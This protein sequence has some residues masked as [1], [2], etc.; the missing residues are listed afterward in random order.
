MDIGTENIDGAPAHIKGRVRYHYAT[1]ALATVEAL[2]RVPMSDV[3]AYISQD[4]ESHALSVLLAK[5]YRW[6]RT[7]G[8]HCVFE[9]AFVVPPHREK[10][11]ASDGN[12]D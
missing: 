9:K 3:G 12:T 2:C 5:G 6:I 1:M 8:E 7:D 11:K 10:G 4:A